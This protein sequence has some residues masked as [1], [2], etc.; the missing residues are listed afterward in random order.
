MIGT[1]AR[2]C[3]RFTRLTISLLLPLHFGCWVESFSASP[4]H[5]KVVVWD[6]VLSSERAETLHLAAKQSG[7]GH[8]LFSRPLDVNNS[9]IIE[10]TLDSILSEMGDDSKYVEYWTRQE[11]RSIEAHADVDEFLAKNQDASGAKDS[12]SFRY[13]NNGH[14]LY[15]KVG[16][17]VRGPTCVFPERRSGGDLL[18]P[19]H[20]N[21]KTVELITVPALPG[22]LLRFKGDYL[23]AVP[24]PTDFWLLKFV[25]G[26]PQF[27]PEEEWG[28]SVVLFN[29]WVEEPPLDVPAD[30]SPQTLES[31]KS[32][33]ISCT[34][35]SDWSKV[36][37]LSEEEEEEATCFP[38][39]GNEE[40][41]SAKIWLLGNE[42]RR[43]YPMRTLKLTAPTSLQ[44]AL[45]EET[46]VSRLLLEQP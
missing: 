6:K 16:S 13:P 15:L 5:T 11:W 7:L 8:K 38:P 43:D 39:A 2:T 40:R 45:E 42:R 32:E 12:S 19:P 3:S 20:N 27:E 24:R 21:S 28:R 18:R 23:H 22:R 35:G 30:N 1:L 9:G 26:A 44:T 37:E 31:L 36:F 17:Q 41:L 10:R 14:V 34:R 25:Q 4:S 46:V 29:A 33:N